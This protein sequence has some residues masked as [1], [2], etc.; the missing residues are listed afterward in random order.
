VH[1]CR[2]DL[3]HVLRIPAAPSAAVQDPAPTT[4]PRSV[5]G[6]TIPAPGSADSQAVSV[7]Y[8]PS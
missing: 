4:A 6:F 2:E 1:R 3:R 5:T 8:Q 7:G